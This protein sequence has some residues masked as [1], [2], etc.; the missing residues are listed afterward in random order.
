MKSLGNSFNTDE[1]YNLCEAHTCQLYCQEDWSDINRLRYKL[2]I[3]KSGATSSPPPC[4]ESLIKHVKRANYVARIWKSATEASI[5]APPPINHGWTLENDEADYSIK[6]HSGVL[7]PDDVLQTV[8]C[9]CKKTSCMS[10]KCACKTAKLPCIE[11]CGCLDCQNAAD[12]ESDIDA[13]EDSGAESD[14][15]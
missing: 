4:K 9:K 6:W 2:F 11:L 8:V 14:V 15:E 13:N 10:N 12:T 3:A 1:V 5:D 7:A